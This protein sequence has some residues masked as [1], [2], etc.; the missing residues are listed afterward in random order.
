[1]I[2]NILEFQ[3][4]WKTYKDGK[5][6][7]VALKGINLEL[8]K[9]S[10]NIILGPSGSG[11]STLLTLTSL[12]ETPTKGKLLINGQNTSNL[13]KSEKSKIRRADIGIIY[14]RDNLFSYLNVLE[15]VMLSMISPNKGEAINTIKLAGLTNIDKFPD[16]LSIEEQQRVAIARAMVNNPLLILA[17][18]PTGELDKK[19]AKKI[20]DLMNQIKEKHTI[21]MVTNN[22]DLGEYSNELFFLKDGKIG[23]NS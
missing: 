2:D 8:Q 23:K 21:L 10:L 9:N 3:D 22:A 16:E 1:M 19:S 14:Q 4:V 12:L 6:E 7:S 13:S 20:M 17:D 18:E 11:K 15:N 5:T